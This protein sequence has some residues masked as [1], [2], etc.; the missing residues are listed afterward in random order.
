MH[1]M[2]AW[3]P[4]RLEGAIGL[5]GIGVTVVNCQCGCWRFNPDPLKEQRVLLSAEPT[6]QPLLLES[7]DIDQA[8]HS[9]SSC[10]SLPSA[11]LQWCVSHSMTHAFKV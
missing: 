11:E 1:R 5:S 2:H 7:Y 6:L 4:Q 10:L 3:D 8:G 9:L